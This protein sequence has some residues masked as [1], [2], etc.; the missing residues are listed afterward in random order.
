MKSKTD[1][2][3]IPLTCSMISMYISVAQGIKFFCTVFRHKANLSKKM[4]VEYAK[5]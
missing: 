3:Y 5:Q 2:I 1:H 4:H